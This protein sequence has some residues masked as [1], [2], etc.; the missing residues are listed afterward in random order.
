[1]NHFYWI[2]SNNETICPW[3]AIKLVLIRQKLLII[4]PIKLIITRYTMVFNLLKVYVLKLKMFRTW[5]WVFK[6][7][8]TQPSLLNLSKLI[9]IHFQI[10]GIKG[11]TCIHD[12]FYYC[13]INKSYCPKK[14][15][16]F[17][18]YSR[19]QNNL[20]IWLTLHNM[21]LFN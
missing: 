9:F 15:R 16:L 3:A 17:W 7:Y 19:N 8:S 21:F 18:S 12:S 14:N 13:L 11:Q 4:L 6:V 1:M 20:I 10:D 2:M 5:V